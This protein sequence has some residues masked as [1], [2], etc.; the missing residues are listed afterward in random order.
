MEED[1]RPYNLQDYYLRILFGSSECKKNLFMIVIQGLL[2]NFGMNNGVLLALKPVSPAIF[3]HRVIVKVNALTTH[4]T[5]SCGHTF[6][7]NHFQHLSM[8]YPIQNLQEIAQLS[9]ALAI[10]P[11][12]CCMHKKSFSM[13]I[14]YLQSYLIVQ[15]NLKLQDY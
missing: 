4:L 10:H 8:H 14:I 2:L 3:T 6:I 15:Y 1:C 5:K 7:T 12:L 11:C 13:S 9:K